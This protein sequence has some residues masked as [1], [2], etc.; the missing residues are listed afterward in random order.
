[1]KVFDRIWFSRTTLAASQRDSAWVPAVHCAIATLGLVAAARA[2]E[3]EPQIP[4]MPATVEEA[5]ALIPR[6]SVLQDQE[7]YRLDVR[8]QACY[9]KLMMAPCL[10]EVKLQRARLDRAYRQLDNQAKTLIR[11]DEFEAKRRAR[12]AAALEAQQKSPVQEA[13]RLQSQQNYDKKAREIEARSASLQPSGK[14]HD[15]QP[16]LPRVPSG[17]TEAE[18]SA[19]RAAFER[20]QAVAADR[21]RANDAR[22]KALAQQRESMV[23]K[24]KQAIDAGKNAERSLQ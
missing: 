24:Q 13:E 5:R 8:E 15:T 12:E 2:A 3:Y 19:N 23:A 21:Q 10:S 16:R 7:K 14:G 17:P 9:E 11:R 1:M 22:L 6:L 4:P 20:K 18:R